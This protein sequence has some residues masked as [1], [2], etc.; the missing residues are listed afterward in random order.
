MKVV[1]CNWRNREHR[2]TLCQEPHRAPFRMIFTLISSPDMMESIQT[3][4][5]KESRNASWKI[6]PFKKLSYCINDNPPGT[7]FFSVY[8][9]KSEV[10]HSPWDLLEEKKLKF[11][12]ASCSL[13]L[14]NSACFLQSLDHIGHIVSESGDLTILGTGD[15]LTH[16]CPA[17]C[18][19]PAPANLLNHACPSKG[20]M[21]P[22]PSWP[23]F[24]CTRNPLV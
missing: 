21:S 8:S 19:C 5:M 22:S 17:L 12:I 10:P 18:N 1:S 9:C 23:R 24:P 6:Y 14:C 13:C 15:Y 20:Q 2:K 16:L 3:E 11:Y 4:Q 7:F